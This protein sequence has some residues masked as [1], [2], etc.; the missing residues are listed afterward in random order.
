LETSSLQLTPARVRVVGL[1][2][3][4]LDRPVGLENLSPRLSWRLESDAR[5][6]RQSA[7]RIWVASSEELLKSGRAD[8]WESGKIRSRKSLGIS[9]QGLTLTSRQRYWWQVQIWD[10][11]NKASAPSEVSWWEMGL[12][13]PQDWIAEWLAVE[14][15]VSRADRE[16]GLHW[17]WGMPTRDETAR[18]FR[19]TFNLP[20]Q[21]QAGELFATANDYALF[22]QITRIWINGV[23]I[24]GTGAWNDDAVEQEHMRVKLQPLSAGEHLI[25][26]EVKTATL[27]RP[28]P[29]MVDSPHKHGLVL[30]ARFALCGGDTMRFA[31]DLRWKTSLVRNEAWYTQIYDDHTWENARRVPISYEPWPSG[32]AMCLRRQFLIDQPVVKARLYA[33]AFGTYEARI[34]GRRV[35][36]ACLSPDRSQYAKRLLYQVYDV[37]DLLRVG[38]NALGVIVGDG[39]YAGFDEGYPWAP[40]PRRV[41]AQLE[42]TLADGSRRIVSTGPGWRIAESAIQRS[43]VRIG[44]VYDARLDQLGWDRSP[45]DDS[46]WLEGQIA[47]TPSCRIVAQASAPIRPT[48]VLK[49]RTISQPTPDAYLFDFGQNFAGWCRV[50]VKG[51]RG[52]QVELRFAELLAP[53][54]EIAEPFMNIGS[55]KRDIFTLRGD[56]AGET[57]EPH[58][59]YRGFRYVQVHGLPLPP[60]LDTLEGV[61]VHTDLKLTGKLR[62]SS[63][64]I[65]QI[66]RNHVWTHRSNYV[67]VPTDCPSREQRGFLEVA[68]ETWD[69]AAFNMDVCAFTSRLM[70][71][72]VD[73]QMAD[74]AFPMAAPA[75]GSTDAIDHIPG[76][77]PGL[78]DAGIILP[79]IAWKRYGDLAIIERNWEAMNRYLQFFLDNNPD[80]ISKNKHG[81]GW[82][83]VLAVEA[84]ALDLLG[85]ACWAYLADLLSQMAEAIGRM[86]DAQRLRGTVSEQVR[87]AFIKTFVKS[88]GTVGSG[89]QTGYV[90]ALKFGLL[91]EG[92]KQA[93]VARLATDI[94]SR[95]VSLTTGFLGTSYILDALT[96]AG[97]PDLAYGLL[98]RTEYPSWGNMV[99]QGNTTIWEGWKGSGGAQNHTG[100]ASI[101]GFLFR[102]I[103]GID[104]ASPGFETIRIH[105]VLDPRVKQG[106]GDYDSIMGRISTDWSQNVDGS[107]SLDV[108]L[109]ANTTALIHLPS[110]RKSRIE[111]GRKTIEHR[112]DLRIAERSD[113]ETVISV[114]SGTYQFKV[115]GFS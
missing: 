27:S 39:W 89:S 67:G 60:T 37:T 101:S 61:V 30:F 63:P 51:T 82:G 36:D 105:P 88:D 53:S 73:D 12:L 112:P 2:T 86:S 111:E 71:N 33:T 41:L 66:W 87:E 78:A 42:F 54:G 109:P 80:Y 32:P 58:F 107:F 92:V 5:N 47:E 46:H 85:T 56:P 110:R 22:A 79:W 7:Y 1:R 104:A 25:A 100:L 68:W 81:A 50:H 72:I 115:S 35:G 83:D 45:F 48:Q 24:A 31:S 44:E 49:P 91:P 11:R 4:Y 74:G 97:A 26:V 59:S 106:G 102:R 18:G 3:D 84:T 75:P 16:A 95:G 94:R 19:F 62:A 9:Y 20:A 69:G 21:A 70:E 23:A 14:D 43:Q 55:P 28:W 15:S 34:N 113:H 64:L 57:F 90:L 52:T 65:E 29:A 6:V 76:S 114:G 98:L 13:N 96:D 93:A 77:S 8:L 10:E 108:S 17:I 40:P 38:G 103:A 99:R